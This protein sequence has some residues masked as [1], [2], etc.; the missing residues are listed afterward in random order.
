MPFL[1]QIIVIITGGFSIGICLARS[2]FG[3][4]HC[5]TKATYMS[6]FEQSCDFSL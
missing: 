4:S 3:D 1:Y 5:A 2:T 6:C